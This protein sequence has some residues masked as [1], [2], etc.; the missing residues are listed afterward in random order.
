MPRSGTYE[1]AGCGPK[2]VELRRDLALDSVVRSS[3]VSVGSTI[4]SLP[5]C[6]IVS[7]L[8]GQG[9]APATLGTPPHA[10]RAPSAGLKDFRWNSV[11]KK[12]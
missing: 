7:M 3:L 4:A 9:A 12:N 8:T 5:M 2:R 10:D 6:S 1:R 11:N